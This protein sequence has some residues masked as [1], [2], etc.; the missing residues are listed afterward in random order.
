MKKMLGLTSTLIC[1]GMHTP[2]RNKDLVDH[3][4]PGA[5]TSN[6]CIFYSSSSSVYEDVQYSHTHLKYAVGT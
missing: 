3:T 6:N 4:Q 5:R 1:G 2:C